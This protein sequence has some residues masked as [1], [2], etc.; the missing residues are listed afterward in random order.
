MHC[1]HEPLLASCRQ[2]TNSW[3]LFQ[4][5]RVHASFV[6]L[7]LVPKSLHWPRILGLLVGVHRHRV[8]VVGQLAHHGVLAWWRE[9]GEVRRVD[10]LG[11][12]VREWLRGVV[13]ELELDLLLVWLHRVKHVVFIVRV[14]WVPHVL[15]LLALIITVVAVLV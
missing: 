2:A 3:I 11:C 9:V 13:T 1:L 4:S 8:G 12:E 5:H 14:R 10:L 15:L 6:L 7:I